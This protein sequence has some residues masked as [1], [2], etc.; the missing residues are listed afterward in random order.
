MKK[1]PQWLLGDNPEFFTDNGIVYAFYQRRLYTF[2]EFPEELMLAVEQAMLKD[3]KAFRAICE[4]KLERDEMLEK[5]VAC[6][7][8]NFDGEADMC[9]ETLQVKAEYVECHLRGICPY[10]GKICKTLKVDDGILTHQEMRVI[11]LITD[12]NL[13]KEIADIL[14]ISKNT[15]QNH[16]A[17]IRQKTGLRSR[18]E[19]ARWAT[20]KNL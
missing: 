9:M 8:G 7:M 11:K 12:G 20:E 13:D 10:E 3:T 15:V 2:Q 14:D 4:F 5:Y 18:A 1:L 16:C 6:V 19:I 17:N